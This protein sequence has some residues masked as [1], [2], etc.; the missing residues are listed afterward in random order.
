MQPEIKARPV[1]LERLDPPLEP[2]RRGGGG[3][4]EG[5]R[6]WLARRKWPLLI[7]VL[8]TLLAGFYFGLI[9]ADRYE[10]E[11]RFVVRSPST[12]TTNQL[13]GLV[14]GSSIV[15]SAEDAYIVHAYMRSRD[16]VRKLVAEAQLLQRLQ[17]PE[18]DPLWSHPGWSK[19]SE[20]RL[21]RHFQSFLTID[22]DSST[23]ISTL[24]VQGFRPADARAIA[25]GLLSSGERLI[26]TMSERS[27]REALR[28]ATGEVERTRARARE[29]LDAISAFRRKHAL[30]DPA[31]S[32][33]AALE[34]I[35]RLALELSKTK[36]EL[37]EVRQTAAD[38]PLARTLAVRIAAFEEQMRQERVA[39]A[40]S[41]GSLAPLIADYER[42]SLE[43][44]F[45]E[46]AFASAQS[47]L[48]IARVDAE[49]Q[50]LFI[51]RISEPGEPDY[52]KYPQRLL[53]I[54]ATFALT[55]TLY[56][57]GVRLVSDTRRHASR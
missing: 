29:T 46:R 42:M 38:G 20:E 54:L 13:T 8:P 22:F 17:R 48:D 33:T 5:A 14:P 10:V 50:R 28:T 31:R 7:V 21:W 49:R 2:T 27:H 1:T 43:R 15:R 41:D 53:M 26:N 52:P 12:A 18:A 40:G 57:V 24:R 39:I 47:A 30:I 44:E 56:V 45:A 32:S 37:N 34:T 36:A 55:G 25:E 9:A 16:A 11:A 51:E 35:T 3:V 4:V 23:G 6:R 19:P